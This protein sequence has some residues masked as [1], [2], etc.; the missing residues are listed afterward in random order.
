M[1]AVAP[2]DLSPAIVE[3]VHLQKCYWVSV[4]LVGVEYQLVHKR[5]LRV[6][7]SLQPTYSIVTSLLFGINWQ[8]DP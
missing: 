7:R 2:V 4:V 6:R 3:G 1:H 5:C 8:Y